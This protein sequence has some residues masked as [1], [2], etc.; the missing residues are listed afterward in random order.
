MADTNRIDLRYIKE[1]T[2]GVAPGTGTYPRLRITSESIAQVSDVTASTAIRS[3]R[4]TA[5]VKR[6]SI[7]VSGDISGE[8]TYGEWD[9]LIQFAMQGAAIS[10]DIADQTG[11]WNIASNVI[12]RPTGDWTTLLSI[13][14]IV[15]LNG[16][17][18][19]ANNGQIGI[20]GAPLSSAFF[21]FEGPTLTD[22]SS[23]SDAIVEGFGSTVNGTTFESISIEKDYTDLTTTLE[24]SVGCGIS[25]FTVNVPVDGIATISF[26]VLGKSSSSTT[27]DDGTPGT[28]ST[29]E[30][31]NAVDNVKPIIEGTGTFTATSVGFTVENSLRGRQQ[32]GTLGNVSVGSGKFLVQGTLQGIFSSSTIIDKFLNQTESQLAIPITDDAGNSMCFY[33][34]AVKYTSASRVTPGEDQD[35]LADLSWSAFMDATQGVMMRYGKHAV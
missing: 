6:T 20:V 23:A 9:E 16:F 1:S 4:Q 11:A 33:F 14:D 8:L 29:N 34:P 5:S 24:L 25:S 12:E 10:A 27:S 28:A 19:A 30:A 31:I 7:G 17:D 26:S 3:D 35:I 15:R 21:T 22:E 18:T 2:Y 32:I 13:G